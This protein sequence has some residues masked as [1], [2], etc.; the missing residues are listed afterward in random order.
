M[1]NRPPKRRFPFRERDYTQVA[2]K[3][4]HGA[5]RKPFSTFLIETNFWPLAFAGKC[6]QQFGFGAVAGFVLGA[7]CLYGYAVVKPL[8]YAKERTN[9]IVQP[10]PLPPAPLKTVQLRGLVRDA[11][12]KPMNDRFW[13][14]VLAKQLGP[15]QNSEG[16]FA[17]EVPQNST[18]DVALWTSED[19]NVYTGFAA[20]QDGTG[21]R[22]QQALP[23]L[24]RAASLQVSR[25]QDSK[26]KTQLARFQFGERSSTVRIK[27]D[28]GRANL[29]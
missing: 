1:Q 26:T 8:P 5:K 6:M 24:L 15:V 11:A 2:A 17:L 29:R 14:G 28:E 4:D 20:E 23:F 27:E 16:S 21:Y 3:D 18:Y 25:S 10:T 12:G 9:P 19:V 22:L 13:V 7:A